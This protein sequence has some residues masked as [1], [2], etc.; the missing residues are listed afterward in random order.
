MTTLDFNCRI[1]QIERSRL[2]HQVKNF[3]NVY[4]MG[5]SSP[6]LTYLEFNEPTSDD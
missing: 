2:E 5:V 6:I 3:R 4:E 1:P